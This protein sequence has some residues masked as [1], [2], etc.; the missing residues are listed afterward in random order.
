MS[1]R[2]RWPPRARERLPARSS[3]LALVAW[4]CAAPSA[5]RTSAPAAA[6]VAPRTE[7]LGAALPGRRP[8]YDF[9]GRQL[10]F[11]S[12][13]EG[14]RDLRV[15]TLATGEQRELN[16]P[17]DDI[18]PVWT[19]DGRIVFASNRDGDYD[20]W[21]IDPESGAVEQLSNLEGDELEPTVAAIP[22]GFYA[23]R[24]GVCGAGAEGQLL[25]AY[26]KVAFV[27]RGPRSSEIWFSSV[28]SELPAELE[29]PQGTAEPRLSPHGAHSGR[30]SRAGARCTEPAFG[31]DGLSLV[32]RCDGAIEDAP[33]EYAQSFDAALAAIQ[34]PPPE[35][36]AEEAD[37]E[38]CWKNLPH[39]YASYPGRAVSEPGAGLAHPA[40][41][42]NQTL[43]LADAAGTP[44]Q[45]A[46]YAPGASWSRLPIEATRA[47]HLSWSPTGDEL[48]FDA[49]GELRRAATHFYLQGVQNLRHF[50][51]LFGAGQSELLQQNAFV[52]RPARHLEF[53]ALHDQ[54]RYAHKPQFISTDA[55]LQAFRDEFARLLEQGERDAEKSLHALTGALREHYLSRATRAR[56][57]PPGAA[58]GA[59]ERDH[60]LAVLFA[61]AWAPLEAAATM[62][63]LDE[64]ERLEAQVAS[65]DAE[66]EARVARLARPVAARLP[67]ELPRV[68]SGLPPS[69]RAEVQQ[70]LDAM[71]AHAGIAPVKVPGRQQPLKVDFSQFAIRGAYAENELGAYFL[72]MNW[73]GALPLPIDASLGELIDTLQH[74]RLGEQSAWAHWQRVNALVGSFMGRPVDATLEDVRLELAA[75]RR[76]DAAD[77]EARLLR[78]RGP[79]PIRDADNEDRALMVT[80]FPKRVGLDVTFF[81]QLTWP[82]LERPMPSALDVFAV[83]GNAR[84]EQHAALGAGDIAARYHELL[85]ALAAKTPA[86][87][88]EHGYA[89]TDL[90][91]GWLALLVTLAA[92]F[93]VPPS[94]ALSF[95]RSAA[96]QDRQLYSALAGYAELKHSAVLYAMQDIGVECDGETSYYVAVEEP[97]VPRPRGFVEPNLPFYEGLAALARRSYQ[98]LYADAAG[99]TSS[100]W[101]SEGEPRLNA[102]SFALDLAE[103]ARTELAG[104]PLSATQAAW[105]EFV[106]AKL[107]PLTL[108]LQKSTELVSTGGAGRQQRGVALVTDVH[109]NSTRG[110]ALALGVGRIFDL[111]VVVPAA[112][113][114]TLTQG[115]SLSFYEFLAPMAQRPTDA[116]WGEQVEAG[117]PPPRPAWT[118]SF[119]EGP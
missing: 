16:G 13:P 18:D 29:P 109:T 8:R 57:A 78:R 69:I 96:W 99:P 47:E 106:A 30:L 33:A 110:T 74:T 20:L 22:F 91:H 113:G 67:E 61:T 112:V 45:R 19:P 42:T 46:R 43:L 31:L 10:V 98:Q 9:G 73:L 1:A 88:G 5:P 21:R 95:A 49:G 4:A 90:Y 14:A 63:R 108:G 44:M 71:L 38:R 100:Q 87:G 3:W 27:R 60:Y 76:F 39:V 85:D 50:P 6:A 104:T 102:L 89:S 66:L 107:E 75:T 119:I 115:G 111:W 97:V 23:V 54:L 35:G 28:R 94:S 52:V 25:D 103:L 83:L 53:Y 93:D 32:W 15:L 81:R 40:I 92:P 41:S 105:I 79:V 34:A 36:C 116:A 80:L 117:Q 65:A 86:A 68:V 118:G 59:A 72:A 24:N 114:Q 56:P 12:G 48:A 26:Q 62:E 51:E 11:M 7:L 64:G 77:F 101:Q 70:H 84:A 58:A 37:L 2:S 55:A 17:G 82:A